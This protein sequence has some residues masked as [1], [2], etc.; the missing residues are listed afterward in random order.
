MSGA[1]L[2]TRPPLPGGSPGAAPSAQQADAGPDVTVVIPVYND[3]LVEQAIASALDQTLRSVDVVVADH[4]STDG[5]G[6]LL[7]RIAAHEP[8]VRVL[9]L[10]DNEGGPGRPL[11][12]AMDAAQGRYITILGSDDELERDACRTLVAGGD[13]E[14]ADLVTSMTRRIHVHEGNRVQAW[15]PRLY[16]R[17]RTLEGIRADLEQVWDQIPVESSSAP[18]GCGIA[19]SGSPRTWSTRTSSS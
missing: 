11:N 8:R 19:T 16:T 12:A 9:H 3:P 4:G 5:T 7:D 13:V 10:P 15:Y 6:G 14:K 2:I 18:T 17:R 1:P